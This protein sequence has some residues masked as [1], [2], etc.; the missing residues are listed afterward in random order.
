MKRLR[1]VSASPNG[2]AWPTTGRPEMKMDLRP[3]SNEKIT[4][5]I[6]QV[7][8]ELHISAA[9]LVTVLSSSKI[10]RIRSDNSEP[11]CRRRNEPLTW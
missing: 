1:A 7:E 4:P 8:D 6:A 11:A 2:K 3:M 5:R 9:R 10:V